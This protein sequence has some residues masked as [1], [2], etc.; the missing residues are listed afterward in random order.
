M[1]KMIR[2]C[3]LDLKWFLFESF[4]RI[5]MAINGIFT[6]RPVICYGCGS[7]MAD[8]DVTLCTKCD[9][10]FCEICE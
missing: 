10:T 8:E 1:R 3:I 5:V 6:R 7:R 9:E 2:Y 4:I